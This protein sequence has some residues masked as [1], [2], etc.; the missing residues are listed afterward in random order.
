[1]SDTTIFIVA[2]VVFILLIIGL[3][4]TVYEFKNNIIIKNQSKRK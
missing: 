3:I 2:I 4:L 1:M